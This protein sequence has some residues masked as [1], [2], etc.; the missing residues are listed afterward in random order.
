MILLCLRSPGETCSGALGALRLT[1]ATCVG[2]AAKGVVLSGRRAGTQRGDEQAIESSAHT[3]LEPELPAVASSRARIENRPFR[4]PGFTEGWAGAFA[5][6]DIYNSP[7]LPPDTAMELAAKRKERIA[8]DPVLGPLQRGAPRPPEYPLFGRRGGRVPRMADGGHAQISAERAKAELRTAVKDTA[9]LSRRHISC[10]EQAMERWA[11]IRDNVDPSDQ[12]NRDLLKWTTSGVHAGK[13]MLQVLT[14][15][16]AM[17]RAKVGEHHVATKRAQEK[18]QA[19]LSMSVEQREQ[20]EKDAKERRKQKKMDKGFTEGRVGMAYELT[21]AEKESR[22]HAAILSTLRQVI[23]AKRSLGGKKITSVKKLFQLIDT[24]DSRIVDMIEFENAL[25]RLGLGLSEDAVRRLGTALDTDGGG[26]ID[27][28]EFEVWM[29]TGE[30]PRAGAYAQ[31]AFSNK[32]RERGGEH[33]QGLADS[34]IEAVAEFQAEEEKKRKKER[35]EL[36]RKAK[37]EKRKALLREEAGKQLF[38]QPYADLLTTWLRDEVNSGGYASTPRMLNQMFAAATAC[39][40]LQN[41]EERQALQLHGEAH[42]QGEDA[43]NCRSDVV[44]KGALLQ[45]V[46]QGANTEDLCGPASAGDHMTEHLSV[47]AP[48]TNNSNETDIGSTEAHLEEPVRAK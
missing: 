42:S 23:K 27:Y 29:K 19:Y 33:G 8:S 40:K 2:M 3:A 36:E 32:R 35:V 15:S 34:A 48:D 6:K 11:H 26:T 43:L 4:S 5:A 37:E 46:L 10:A 21:A 31:E 30:V 41:Q 24:D 16:L 13:S 20:A 45:M 14:D 44:I 22:S 39:S 47:P 1:P 18:L 25:T 17:R 28:G 38:V 12:S 7:R 9:V